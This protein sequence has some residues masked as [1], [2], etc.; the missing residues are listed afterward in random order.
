MMVRISVIIAPFPLAATKALVSYPALAPLPPV[1][2]PFHGIRREIQLR[3]PVSLGQGFAC[4][5][6]A[7]LLLVS[8][9]G[10]RSDHGRSLINH[11]HMIFAKTIRYSGL[12]ALSTWDCGDLLFVCLLPFGDHFFGLIGLALPLFCSDFAAIP[13]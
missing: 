7:M 9:S 11:A 13:L 5:K 6:S 3:C 10:A 1:Y 2:A 4:S 12:R 8:L